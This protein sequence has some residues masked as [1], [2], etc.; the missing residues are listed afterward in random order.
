MHPRNTDST[1][2]LPFFFLMNK[3]QS[4]DPCCLFVVV[5]TWNHNISRTPTK[6]CSKTQTKLQNTSRAESSSSSTFCRITKP[7]GVLER[8]RKREWEEISSPRDTLPASTDGDGRRKGGGA[9]T[10]WWEDRREELVGVASEVGVLEVVHES[11]SSLHYTWQ[12]ITIRS[13]LIAASMP[14]ESNNM[15]RVA[16]RG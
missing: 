13:A 2:Y 3:K 16:V 5:G 8:E 12:Y 10:R 11:F 4:F 1:R 15:K 9:V 6:I 14:V 7:K